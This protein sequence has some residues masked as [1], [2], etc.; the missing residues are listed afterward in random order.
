MHCGACVRRVT[1]ALE[2]LAGPGQAQVEVGHA[3]VT[4]EGAD[5]PPAQELIDAV[6][7]LGFTARLA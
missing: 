5:A 1:V 2:K 4:L 6:E 7:R 3:V